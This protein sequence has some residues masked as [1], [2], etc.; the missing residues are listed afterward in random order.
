MSRVG[1]RLPEPPDKY[2][3]PHEAQ[4]NRELEQ[5]DGN[6]VKRGEDHHISG[7]LWLP[8]PDGIWWKVKVDRAGV[9]YTQS[10]LSAVLDSTLDEASLSSTVAVT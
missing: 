3:P 1:M 6:N 2:S 8:D 9:L 10:G 4:R 7:D 5:A